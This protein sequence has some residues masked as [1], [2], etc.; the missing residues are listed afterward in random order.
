MILDDLT[1]EN[2]IDEVDTK[3]L[4]FSSTRPYD[5]KSLTLLFL[6]LTSQCIALFVVSGSIKKLFSIDYFNIYLFSLFL[7]IDFVRF[8]GVN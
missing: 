4:K 1:P 7:P 6:K 5:Y 8:R 3:L 2:P